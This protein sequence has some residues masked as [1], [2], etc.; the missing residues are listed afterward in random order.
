M[1][2]P[3]QG[4]QDNSMGIIW[5]IAAFFLAIIVIWTVF[6][7]QLVTG[8]LTLK[9]YEHN[10][11]M[12]VFGDQPQA[13]E[14]HQTLQAAI[15]DPK[16]LKFEDVTELGEMVSAIPKYF[17][18]GLMFLLGMIIYLGNSAQVFKRTYSMK[19]LALAE[20]KNYPQISPVVKL[21]LIKDDIDKGPWAM[22]LTPIQFC[23]RYELLEE[24]RPQRRE[25]MSR[26]EWDKV[27]VLL[28]RGRANKIFA[29]QLGMLWPGPEKL[30]PHAR[31]LFSA[32][33]ARL[34]ADSKPASEL[35]M[36]LARTCTKQLDITGTDE[37]IKKHIKTE[38]VQKL[39]NT[40]AYTYTVMM[41]ALKGAREDGVQASADFL[42][43]KPLDRRLWYTLNTVGRQTPF[44][45]VA[46]IFAHWRS[47]QEAGRRLLVPMVEEATKALELALQEVVYKPD[48]D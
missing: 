40:H 37:L 16:S 31:A 5:I 6:K 39:L 1:A 36:Q 29:M 30:P 25:G 19:D 4:G 41:G 38:A 46:G 45:E 22:A 15:A 14:L 42:W 8:Y 23:K 2:A 48:K 33:I 34:N 28:R 18:M 27:E 21:D 47:E 12:L 24:V 13:R 26:S 43:L 9:L 10:L 7:V 20:V 32:F 3:Q 35:L 11:V 44:V 17:F